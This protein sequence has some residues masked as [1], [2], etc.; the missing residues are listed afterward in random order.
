MITLQS[1]LLVAL[2]ATGV[3]FFLSFAIAAQSQVDVPQLYQ[4]SYDLE[5]VADYQGSLDAMSA[6]PFTERG[7]FVFQLRRGWL[8]YLLGDFDG[9]VD[10]YVSAAETEPD[11]IEVMLGVQLPQI[12]LRRWQDVRDTSEA[13][14]AVDPLN[15]TARRRLGLALYSL[16]RYADAER[17]YRD[18]L[19][20]YPSDVEMRAGLGWSLLMQGD[21]A[22][23]ERAFRE[24]LRVSPNQ[25]GV[26]EA[27]L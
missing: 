26:A 1:R 7:Q 12:A 2:A 18:V 8:L 11:A 20:H 27:M 3:V 15:Y 4:Q 10:A 9:S 16:G 17:V 6:M 22:G 14:L 5:A 21:E 25:A 23:A 24:V 19:R 13:I